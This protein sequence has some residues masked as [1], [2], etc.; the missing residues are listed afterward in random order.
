[1][2]KVEDDGKKL[3]CHIESLAKKHNTSSDSIYDTI[4]SKFSVAKKLENFFIADTN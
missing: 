1:M 2:K 3:A 4:K